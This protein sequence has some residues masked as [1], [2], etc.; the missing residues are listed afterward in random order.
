MDIT[1][2]MVVELAE[3]VFE[4]YEE[5]D[6]CFLGWNVVD[7]VSHPMILQ[8]NICYK[9]G[10]HLYPLTEVNVESVIGY[11]MRRNIYAVMG[12]EGEEIKLYVSK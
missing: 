4:S 3:N 2:E 12:K 8:I 10:L 11:F 1:H 7:G 5:R 6:G 9:P